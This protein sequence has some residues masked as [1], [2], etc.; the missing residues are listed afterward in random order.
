MPHSYED[1]NIVSPLFNGFSRL[2][3]MLQFRYINDNLNSIIADAAHEG[4]FLDVKACIK[5]GISPKA[6]E[7]AL[8]N[9]E[10]SK[11]PSIV[12]FL[13]YNFPQELI[14]NKY[15]ILKRLLHLAIFSNNTNVVPI[16]C[17]AFPQ[18]LT[19]KKSDLLKE[20][21]FHEVKTLEMANIIQLAA[22]ELKFNTDELTECLF[23]KAYG[24]PQMVEWL[25]QQGADVN[26]IKLDRWGKSC[27]PLMRAVDSRSSSTVE[28]LCTFGADIEKQ[29]TRQSA[30][31]M[32]RGLMDKT[33]LNLLLSQLE[34]QKKSVHNLHRFFEQIK[35]DTSSP[36][37]EQSIPSITKDVEALI[38]SYS[39]LEI[40]RHA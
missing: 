19:H 12:F 7:K 17:D 23:E 4:N 22:P 25:C 16:I 24:S 3:K 37:R 18:E 8:F 10:F 6:F 32:S 34:F 28:I 26:A 36:A 35:T 30:I 38:H 14:P 1:I 9:A 2:K 13:L 39:G 21:L 20:M 40:T 15:D 29:T 27:T 31:E 33:I 5:Y 11:H